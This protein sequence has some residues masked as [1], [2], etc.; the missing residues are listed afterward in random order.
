MRAIFVYELGGVGI[1]RGL[2]GL[3]GG[4]IFNV[5]D[6]LDLSL[7]LRNSSSTV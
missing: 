2:V 7:L 3:D 4:G 1:S 6:A 5:A